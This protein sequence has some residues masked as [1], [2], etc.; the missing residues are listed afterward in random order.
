VQQVLLPLGWSARPVGQL[1][2]L[3][4]LVELVEPVFLPP[5]VAQAMV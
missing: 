1:L 2:V 5:G 4:L 3:Q